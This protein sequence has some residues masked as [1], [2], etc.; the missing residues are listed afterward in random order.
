[1]EAHILEVIV[2]TVHR[3]L[4]IRTLSMIRVGPDL[5]LPCSAHLL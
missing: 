1:L 4:H 3:K 2:E 5:R